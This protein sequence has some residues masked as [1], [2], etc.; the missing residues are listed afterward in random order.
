MKSIRA[1][2]AALVAA[3]LAIVFA[4]ARRASKK[5]GKGLVASLPDVPGEAQRLASD[6]KSRATETVSGVKTASE[7]GEADVTW[8]AEGK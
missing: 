3:V 7:A 6:V 8:A 4:L 5:T 2:L 1:V